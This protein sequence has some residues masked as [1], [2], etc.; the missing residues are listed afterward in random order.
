[1][2]YLNCHPRIRCRGEILNSDYVFYGNPRGMEKERLKLHIESFFVK[3]RNTLVGAKILTY[4]LD[5]AQITLD[6]LLELLHQP[7]IIVLYREQ[8]LE[9]YASL[10]LA[11]HT[12]VWHSNKPAVS[13]PIR[14][15]RR[16]FVGFAERELR[17]WRENLDALDVSGVHYVT[18]EELTRRPNEA[19]RD[20]FEFL[21]L[22]SCPVE[23]FV[24]KLHDKP[25]SGK[26]ANYDEFGESEMPANSILRLPFPSEIEKRKAA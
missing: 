21:G 5:E 7:R 1:V 20:V 10:K 17:M 12:G 25:L 3:R 2:D 18:Y 15:D 13:D 22:K 26:L 6:D 24:V 14:I 16:D 23:S 11:E 9:Q 8:I 19:M 4:Q